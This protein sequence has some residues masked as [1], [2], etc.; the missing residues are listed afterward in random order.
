MSADQP[1]DM[2]PDLFESG[3]A[4]FHGG[5]RDPALWLNNYYRGGWFAASSRDADADPLGLLKDGPNAFEQWFA[6][7]TAALKIPSGLDHVDPAF[8]AELTTAYLTSL[9]RMNKDAYQAGIDKA[10]SER[11]ASS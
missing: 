9:Q 7:F 2:R 5:H 1:D 10:D 3:W 4:D 11:S 8:V 6:T